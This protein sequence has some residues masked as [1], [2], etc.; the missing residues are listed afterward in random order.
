MAF[1]WHPCSFD[2]K[3]YWRQLP[4]LPAA[5]FVTAMDSG[6]LA[7]DA[8]L[9]IGEYRRE[10]DA[11]LAAIRTLTDGPAAAIFVVS[12]ISPLPG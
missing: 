2:F 8:A 9:V 5:I 11:G 6:P 4:T 3:F 10:F 1:L 7:A 12:P